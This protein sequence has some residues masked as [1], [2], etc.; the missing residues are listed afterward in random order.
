MAE[1]KVDTWEELQVALH[2]AAN[3]HPDETGWRIYQYM[4]AN[5]DELESEF[6]RTLLLC[7]MKLP[8]T[9]P[10]LLHS[11]ILALALKMADK[12]ADF[13][14]VPFLRMWNQGATD[15]CLRSDDYERGEKDGKTYA[16][17]SERLAQAYV[18]ALLNAPEDRLDST[19]HSTL[20]GI[21]RKMG[22]QG[23]MP[24][25]AVKIFET[26]NEGKKIRSVKMIGGK[27]EELIVDRHLFNCR[28]WEICG[29]LYDVLLRQSQKTERLRAEAVA[30]SSKTI[31]D[32]FPPVIG[33][34]D[35]IDLKHS[36]Y[37]IFDSQSRHFV[38]ENPIPAPKI[39]QFVRFCPII[40]AVD[41]FKSAVVLDIIPQGDGRKMFGIHQLH[42]TS[43]NAEKEYYTYTIEGEVNADEM[44]PTGIIFFNECNRRPNTGDVV[45]AIVFLRRCADGK[46]RNRAILL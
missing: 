16:A 13:R 34:V 1:T 33:Y 18:R 41:K 21:A 30:L 38:A 23:I 6:A 45:D 28:P 7:Y 15:W 46:K 29:Q 25:V 4:K 43:I 2:N 9:R 5:F 24:M 14:L 31:V 32:V 12:F 35:G 26:E 19:Q 40:P 11:C 3:S 8:C 42:I 17:L 44:E 10:S 22:Y 36:H 37:H 39:G 27:G 20:V